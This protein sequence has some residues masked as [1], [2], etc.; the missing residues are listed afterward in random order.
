MLLLD[1]VPG[2]KKQ[3][4][5]NERNLPDVPSHHP[6]EPVCIHFQYPHQVPSN[7]LDATGVPNMSKTRWSVYQDLASTVREEWAQ[8][9]PQNPIH[10]A[11]RVWGPGGGGE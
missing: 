6:H 1:L 2:A 3:N 5:R 10:L 7:V 4:P 11:A 9:S 8:S